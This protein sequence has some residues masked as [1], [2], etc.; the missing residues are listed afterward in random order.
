MDI[1]LRWAA[2]AVLGLG[3]AGCATNPRYTKN[4]SAPP[5]THAEAT[6]Q[7]LPPPSA[8]VVAAVYD[9]SD[10]TGQFK[11][12]DTVTTYSRAVSQG[13][14][15]ILIKALQEAGNSSWYTVVERKEL[16]HLLTE[17]AIIRDMRSNYAAK[18]GRQLPPPPPMLYAGVLFEGGIIGYDSN[19]LT[20]GLGA[21]YLGIGGDVDYREDTVTVYLRA[22][23][24]Q[25]GEVLH[26][27]VS[28]KSILSYGLAA[29]VFKFIGFK[30][31]LEIDAGVTTNEPGL[32]ALKQAVE[33][34]VYRMTVEGAQ[35]GLW[36]FAD[37]AAGAKVIQSYETANDTQNLARRT[38]E[39]QR[40]SKESGPTRKTPIPRDQ[41]A[42][43]LGPRGPG[44]AMR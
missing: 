37:K 17:R 7:S 4:P 10:Q 41:Q 30:D 19:S 33:D 22:T 2:L 21:R 35:M 1:R 6:L 34:A 12:S 18:N 11:P 15:A 8:R 26:S 9:F 31:L 25:T 32:I 24:T 40:M 3:L 42:P 38:A 23:S 43:L 44:V 29:N 13:G 27:V 28:Q 39:L 14:A 5:R 36:G 16:Q 20:G